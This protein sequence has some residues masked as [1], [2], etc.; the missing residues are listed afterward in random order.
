MLNSMRR[1]GG[2]MEK[3]EE[4]KTCLFVKL[5][6]LF[7]FI[8]VIRGIILTAKE[9]SKKLTKKMD[10]ENEGKQR[11]CFPCVFSGKQISF[12]GEEVPDMEIDCALGG[13]DIDLTGATL[14][15]TTDITI[16]TALGGVNI[17]VPPM[18]RVKLFSKNLA[19]GVANMVPEYE[20]EDL[21]VVNIN[22]QALMSGISVKVV[23]ENQETD[24]E[25][26]T[27]A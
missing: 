18:V 7:I 2:F 20:S 4:K 22:A 25:E 12:R 3:C 23:D 24:S 14:K 16:R 13:V 5:F 27:E 17:K 11:K 10:E 21:P 15:D 26:T 8:M 1:N 19:S 6:R 9:I